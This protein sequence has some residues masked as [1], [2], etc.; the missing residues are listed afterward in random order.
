MSRAPEKRRKP[1]GLEPRLEAVSRLRAVLAGS[2][3][4]PFGSGEIADPRDRALANR[5][6]TAALRRHGHISAILA[7]TLP[8]GIPP[9]SGTFEAALRTGIA[10][11]LYLPD[12]PD[13]SALDL[14]V[15]AT[16]ADPRARPF[17]RLANGVLRNVQRRAAE[18][19]ALD[20]ALLFPNWLAERWRTHYGADALPRFAEALSETPPLDLSPVIPADAGL[21]ETLGA[22]P[23]LDFSLRLSTRDAAV[24]DLPGFSEGRFWVQDAAAALPARLLGARSGQSVLDICAAPGGKTAQLCAV[25]AEVTALDIDAAR[26]ARVGENLARLG[27]AAEIVTA[28]ALDYAPAAPFDAVLLDAP[29]SATGTFRRHP[30]VLFQRNASG[31][32]ERA[33]LQRRMIERAAALLAPGGTL[34]YCVCS[35]EAEEGED[36]AGWIRTAPHL[37]LDHVPIAAS[38]VAGWSEAITEAGDL[39]THP[40]LAIPSPASGTLDGFFATRF[41]KRA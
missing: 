8:K 30:E 33:A 21:A 29:C 25:G 37:G 16:K 5:I 22:T 32:A 40:G 19:T 3:F 38:E 11:L 36:Q 12:I 13:H 18:F 34:V 17:A 1:I 15:E 39:R 27:F 2:P 20:P 41:T 35:L 26:M 28:D 24:A 6:V 4:R 7:A 10:Q 9:R 14:A 23:V 31:I